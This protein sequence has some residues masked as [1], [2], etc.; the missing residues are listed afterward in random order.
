MDNVLIKFT[1]DSG[2]LDEANQKLEKLNK[3]EKDLVARMKELETQK[4][5]AKFYAKN[6]EEQAAAEQKFGK[7][8]A[9]TSK[10]LQA[11]R[12]SMEELSK[13]QKSL[14]DNVVTGTTQM[15]SAK[16]RLA[17]MREELVRMTEAGK[18]GS[19]EF[20]ALAK[21][22]GELD[23]A[24]K[25][26]RKQ[27]A[28]T[29]SD[30]RAF[31]TLNESAQLVAGS[32]SIAQGA[33]ALFGMEGKDL[34]EMMVKL[35]S[36][37]AITTGLQSVGNALQKESNVLR[38]VS[39]IQTKAAA[40]AEVLLAEGTTSATIAGRAFN[41]VA[42]AN[43]YVLI[44]TAIISVVGA[45]YLFS[46]G[47]EDAKDKQ[48]ELGDAVDQLNGKLD[49]QSRI[50]K[51]MGKSDLDIAK[52]KYESTKNELAQS[53]SLIAAYEKRQQILKNGTE[54]ERAALFSK[55][56]LTATSKQL[57]QEEYEAEKEKNK[58]LT[59]ELNKYYKDKVVA[60]IQ[61]NKDLTDKEKLAAKDRA[62]AIK[63]IE[64]ELQD[65]RI[66]EMPKGMNLEL[67]IL[68]ITHERKIAAIK[69]SSKVENDLRK[70]LEKN[71]HQD[72]E[73]ITNK[74]TLNSIKTSKDE[75][76]TKKQYFKEGADAIKQMGEDIT[77]NE[78]YQAEIRKQVEEDVA[79]T[80]RDLQQM[81]VDVLKDFLS[82]QFSAESNRLNM[83]LD[84][85][86]RY[87][88]TDVE[89]AKKNR[90]LK[91]ITQQE[92][93]KREGD[94]KKKIKEADKT[95]KKAAV[96]INS[97]ETLAKLFF[98]AAKIKANAAVL[99]AN[100]LTAAYAPVALSMLPL[101]Y[102]QMGLVGISSSLQIA[103]I[104]KYAKGRKGGG[105][106]MAWVGE[107]GPEIMWVP[108][109]ASIVPAHK[110]NKLADAV[111]I[112]RE[113]NIPMSPQISDK[114]IND[115]GN[116][117]GIDYDLLA[118]KIGKEIKGNIRI[119]G[120][121]PVSV[122]VDHSGISITDGNTTTHYLNKKYSGDV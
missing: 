104:N 118:S 51:A 27:I 105:G 3:T 57:T 15:K 16:S 60:T 117:N 82:M 61:S 19:K 12:K 97:A 98:E 23:D 107:Q 72:I 86:N 26:V 46:S 44:A 41:L 70:Q 28:D 119:P 39:T 99:A 106:E 122:N 40:A 42:K 71:Y 63:T 18:G 64:K 102:A 74:Y 25:D 7:Q 38:M 35:Q 111:G 4:N 96:G 91:L 108:D 2:G 11:N 45:L 13:A 114:Q 87:Y 9:E 29:G 48:N 14:N 36:A 113:Y 80:K 78:E 92:Y 77:K 30:T 66:D 10:Q 21:K 59:E 43:P 88:T 79:N 89:A 68:R 116:G 49:Y 69:G 120:Q 83:Q 54:A 90:S 115:I 24:M 20:E 81:S 121:R 95:A 94:L 85:L 58:K 50:M 103:A 47:T 34:E 75:S 32:F 17:E 110:S 22:A 53:N 37:I 93:D 52:F 101:V 56:S 65:A 84:D 100:P 62:L 67:E 76:D 73:E 8:I 109:G 55:V 112:M 33:A 31:D 6:A 5:T 1:A